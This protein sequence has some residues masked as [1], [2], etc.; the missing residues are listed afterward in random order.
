MDGTGLA[1]SPVAKGGYAMMIEH[2]DVEKLIHAARAL[3]AGIMG[4]AVAVGGTVT[5]AT[6]MF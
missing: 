3:A 4:L 6:A 1:T 5:L 2:R